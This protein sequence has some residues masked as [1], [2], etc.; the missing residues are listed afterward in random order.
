MIAP[1]LYPNVPEGDYRAWPAL[2]FSG[3]KH[4]LKSG[5]HFR[6]AIDHP[7]PA[8][9]ATEL[10]TDVHTRVL[11]GRAAFE[12]MYLALPEGLDLRRT[13]DKKIRDELRAQ[14]EAE[15]RVIRPA[16]SMAIIEAMAASVEAHPLAM[17]LL[18]GAEIELSMAFTDPVTGCPAKGRLDAYRRD[19]GAV[20]D[21]KTCLDA[22]PGAFARQC[23]AY[24]YGLQTHAY[25]TACRAL[26]VEAESFLF[27]ALEKAPP[28]CCAIYAAPA[29]LIELGKRRWEKA[30]LR[31][32][33]YTASG[34]WPGYQ[35]D[36]QELT[37]PGWALSELFE[38]TS[39]ET[40]DETI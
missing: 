4:L 36:I 30:C 9:A 6:Q 33:E 14:A 25:L 19:A 3:A 12:R 1:G 21:L 16:A 22:S 17:A 39:D 29:A 5:A 28:H 23:L 34:E 24:G 32:V 40:S 35:R 2:S 15:G 37:L 38:E 27:I 10:G 20:I 7:P 26:G 31:Y 13:A 11:A 8:T 18:E